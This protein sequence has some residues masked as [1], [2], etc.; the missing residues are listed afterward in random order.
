MSVVQDPMTGLGFQELSMRLKSVLA[1]LVAV[2][3]FDFDRPH[4]PQGWVQDREVRHWVY[5]PR[6]HH[7]YLTHAATHSHKADP[8][9]YRYEPNGYYPYYNSGY[10]KKRHEIAR[11]RPHHSQP[12]YYAGWGAKKKNYKHVQWHKSH[13]GGHDHAHW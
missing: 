9:A 8:Y 13:H 4:P 7:V 11:N 2:E 5:Y 6:Y 3:A 10:W 12:K 1:A